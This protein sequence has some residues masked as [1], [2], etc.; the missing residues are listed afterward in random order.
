[1]CGKKALKESIETFNK[2][3]LAY[4]NKF[5]N[6]DLYNETYDMFCD[7]VKV[8]APKILEIG[9]GPGNITQYLLKKHP[10]FN[11]TGIDLAENMVALA[12][13]SA[14]KANFRVMDCRD[15]STLNHKF[16]A[17]MCGFCMP[18][19]NKTECYKLIYDCAQLLNTGGILY[20]STMEEDDAHTSG[21]ET[22]SFSGDKRI[23]F[24]Y[25]KQTDLRQSL[26][27]NGFE[28]IS[29]TT[30]KYPEADGSF[31]TDMIFIV[32]KK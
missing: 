23:F 30:Q 15:I 27:N 1:M 18:F 12:K 8:K 13:Q 5:M 16:D 26:I 22:T 25:H 17:I 4:Q 24:N 21:F 20:I 6:L 11:I 10:D 9:T 28:I 3:A 32:S 31:L 14:P 19:L 7:M 2:T 29:A